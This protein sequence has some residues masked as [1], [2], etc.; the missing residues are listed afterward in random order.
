MVCGIYYSYYKLEGLINKLIE[1]Y[2]I[3]YGALY[4]DINSKL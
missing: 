1:E 3:E 2:D 4:P